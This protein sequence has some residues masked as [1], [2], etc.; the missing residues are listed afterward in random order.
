MWFPAIQVTDKRK[1]FDCF[2][3]SD[4][5]FPGSSR[6]QPAAHETVVVWRFL[7][8][9]LRSTTSVCNLLTTWSCNIQNRAQL[10]VRAPSPFSFSYQPL[11]PTDCT[12]ESRTPYKTWSEGSSTFSSTRSIKLHKKHGVFI[13][14][15]T[16]SLQYAN[17]IFLQEAKYFTILHIFCRSR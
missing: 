8:R 10:G 6:V 5:L 9:F 11:E 4:F 12:S 14:H 7:L 2:G 1:S 17:A 3:T 13:L 15:T 16:S